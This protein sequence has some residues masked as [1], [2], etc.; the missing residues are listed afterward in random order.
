M[1]ADLIDLCHVVTLT[2]MAVK[3]HDLSLVKMMTN[4]H[5][6]QDTIPGF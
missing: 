2:K 3:Q 6:C 4:L 1:D 5:G